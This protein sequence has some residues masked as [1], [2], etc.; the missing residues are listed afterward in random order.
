MESVYYIVCLIPDLG[1]NPFGFI[2]F[3]FLPAFRHEGTSSHGNLEG[4]SEKGRL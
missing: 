3:M 2:L 4:V 1:E